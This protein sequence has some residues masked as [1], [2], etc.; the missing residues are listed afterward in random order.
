MH[1][2]DG[3]FS[4]F[5]RLLIAA[6]LSGL[7]GFEREAH[8]Q[9]AGFRTYMIVGI[10]S[11]LM[12]LL[13]LHMEEIYRQFNVNQSVVRLDPGRIASYAI[14]SMGF[15]GAGAI[16]KGRGSVRGLTTAAGLWVVTG[17]GLSIG[18][19]YIL[20]TLFATVLILVALYWLHP[21]RE[22]AGRRNYSLLTIRNVG[23]QDPLDHIRTIISD[24]PQVTIQNINYEHELSS[25]TITYRVR[26]YSKEEEKHWEALTKKLAS[27]QG[28]AEI[29]WEESDVP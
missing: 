20:Q 7:I 11:C 21:I 8:G 25:Q 14:A 29:K 23:L 24:F 2:W 22:L 19:G 4:D 16:I 15:L 5:G 10:G 18:A 17:M 13:S 3:I 28:V 26:V 9:A 6:F 27:I 12:M 1:Y